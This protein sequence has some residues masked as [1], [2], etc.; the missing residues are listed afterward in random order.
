MKREDIPCNETPIQIAIVD[1]LRM[2]LPKDKVHH[3]PNGEKRDKKTAAIL[4]RMGV[5]AGWPDITIMTH[6]GRCVFLEVKRAKGGR[7]SKDQE[8]FRDFCL[9]AKIPWAETRSIDAA[10]E[11]LRMFGVQTREASFD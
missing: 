11:A 8:D 5:L 6:D 10:R 2:V 1:W 4:K 3:S 9:A 7:L